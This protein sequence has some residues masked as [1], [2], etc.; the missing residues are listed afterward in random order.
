MTFLTTKLRLA[1]LALGL[2]V[3]GTAIVPSQAAMLTEKSGSDFS[4]HDCLS[5]GEVKYYFR[6][7]GLEH[8]SVQRTSERYLYK[9]SGYAE[10]KKALVSDN[11]P[12]EDLLRQKSDKV[13]YVVLFDACEERIVRQIQPRLEEAM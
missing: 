3:A 13:H 2:V 5:R 1:A 7:K 12:A 9:V 11:G 10:L 6:E 4:E 8:I